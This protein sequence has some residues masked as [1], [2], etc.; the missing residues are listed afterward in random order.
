[1]SKVDVRGAKRKCQNEECFASFYDLNREEFSCPN[2]GTTYDHKVH[3]KAQEQASSYTVRKRPRVLP[4]TAPDG[5][6]AKAT[7]S[8]SAIEP[9]P[10]DPADVILDAEDDDEQTDI[11]P[12]GTKSNDEQ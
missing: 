10:N 6:E 4:I 8:G 2:C 11:I 12:L 9:V 3:A 1:M 5:D 7:E